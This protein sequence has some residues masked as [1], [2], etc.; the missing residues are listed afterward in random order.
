MTLLTP[1]ASLHFN[2]SPS[3][4]ADSS[5]TLW[6]PST[7]YTGI[8]HSNLT[9]SSPTHTTHRLEVTPFVFQSLWSKTTLQNISSPVG[10]FN[11]GTLSQKNL[12]LPA[13][14]HYL[15]TNYLKSTYPNFLSYLRTSNNTHPCITMT[16]HQYLTNKIGISN[17]FCTFYLFLFAFMNHYVIFIILQSNIMYA[18]ILL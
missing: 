3:N 9:P 11:H 7:S 17:I 12:F 4:T 2:F 6:Q 14:F 10:L 18:F 8:P 5:Q 16:Y 13:A 1:T 15:N